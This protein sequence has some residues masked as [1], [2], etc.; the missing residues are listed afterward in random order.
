MKLSLDRFHCINS[1]LQVKLSNISYIGILFKVHFIQV[2]L[3]NISYIRTLFKVHFIQ[4]KLSN[5]SYI[6]ILF[7]VHFIQVKLSNISYIGT[8]FREKLV[9]MKLSLDR[10]HCINSYLNEL[11]LLICEITACN[12]EDNPEL[13]PSCY[14]VYSPLSLTCI[15][16][17]KQYGEVT[18]T[19][20]HV[21]YYTGSMV[22]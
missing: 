6:G 15:L 21:Y 17:Y 19:L 10:F 13:T 18:M 7:K 11:K 1:Y 2:K 20:I 16:L 9:P 4:V 22:R 8:L 3:S 12:V 5:I 14:Q